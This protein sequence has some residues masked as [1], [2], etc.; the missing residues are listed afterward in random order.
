ME[1]SGQPHAPAVLRFGRIPRYAF[2]TRLD[3][4]QC[5]LG[6]FGLEK[7][8]PAGIRIPDCPA[9]S[10]ACNIIAAAFTAIFTTITIIPFITEYFGVTALFYY[11]V[12]FR[13]FMYLRKTTIS[14]VMSVWLS[15]RMEQL[16]FHWTDFHEI[17]YLSILGIAVE[18]I[19]V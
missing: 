18:K 16:C 6:H 17:L 7:I 4:S 13:L 5:W 15:I 19:Q 8:T 3:G 9:R 10:L 1:L 12:M 14:L 11:Y 2:N